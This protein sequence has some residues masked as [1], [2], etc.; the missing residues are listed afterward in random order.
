[1][2]HRHFCYYYWMRSIF[3]LLVVIG[4]G[5]AALVSAAPE[6]QDKVVFLDVGQGDSIL[7]Q[8]K[9]V[10]V[11]IDG[12]PGMKVLERL[13]EEMPWFDREIEV[14]IATHPD[15]DHLEG[16][17]HVLERYKVGVVIL[18]AVRHT[19]QLQEAWLDHL[20]EAVKSHQVAY[21]FAWPGQRLDFDQLQVAVLSPF[22]P[23]TTQTTNNASVITRVE[24]HGL[25]LLLTGDAEMAIE[26][27]LVEVYSP[28]AL[29]VDI[30]KAGHHGSQT[31][32]SQALID[33]TSPA[34]VVISAGKDNRYGHPHP[35]VLER[36]K[37][38]PIA[39]T[40]QDGSIGLLYTD[41]RWFF[42]TGTLF[43]N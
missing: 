35:L 2:D 25:T 5:V 29:D 41:N 32:T 27:Q 6:P 20:I 14:L 10:Q 19:S 23:F 37:H 33:A 22:P 24:T 9:T 1:M 28:D 13:G 16:L 17:L 40:D 36:L 38:I 31:S 30:L 11:L 42:S 26:R 34:L 7:I 12:G 4:C 39:R 43:Q 8:N 18:P 21:R 3:W 15:K